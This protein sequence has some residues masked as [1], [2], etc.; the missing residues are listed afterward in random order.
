MKTEKVSDVK[1]LWKSRIAQL[2]EK[3]GM[4]VAK[5]SR[6]S[7][8]PDDRLRAWLK[9]K[10]DPSFRDF[11]KIAGALGVPAWYLLVEDAAEI[12]PQDPARVAELKAKVEA[13]LERRREAAR[14]VGAMLEGFTAAEVLEILK[15]NI[16]DRASLAASYGEDQSIWPPEIKSILGWTSSK[17]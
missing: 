16:P 5:L 1:K 17:R 11:G 7:G 6:E 13:Q 3:K 12:S 10:A 14:M 2:I 15:P 4:T 8:I 9:D